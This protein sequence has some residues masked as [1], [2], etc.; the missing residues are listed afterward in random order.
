VVFATPGKGKKTL[1]ACRRFLEEHGGDARNIA[2]VVADMSGAFIA[3]IK[4]H[5]E[6]SEITVDW[7]HVVQLLTKA[8]DEVRRAEAKTEP[9]PKPFAGP[10]STAR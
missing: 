2:G 4:T 1:A 10:R 9:F 6:N 8:L 7:F 5:F 3:G